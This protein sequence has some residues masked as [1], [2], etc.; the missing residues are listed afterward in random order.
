LFDD[1]RT[2][3]RGAGGERSAVVDRN[4]LKPGC[5]GDQDRPI[6]FFG[7]GL[8]GRGWPWRRGAGLSAMNRTQINEAGRRIGRVPVN[9]V[10]AGP[11][12]AALV[13]YTQDLK[14]YCRVTLFVQNGRVASFSADHA[15][16]EFFGLRDGSSYC[17]RIFQACLR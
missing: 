13:Y 14:N 5:G 9:P 8:S 10:M 6:A 17:G 7:D 12:T 11:G 15:A 2:I 16:P 4:G 3:D 1:R